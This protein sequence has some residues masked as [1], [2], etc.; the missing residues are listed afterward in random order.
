MCHFFIQKI[1]LFVIFSEESH[2]SNRFE[3]LYSCKQRKLSRLRTLCFLST[4]NRRLIFTNCNFLTCINAFY[5]IIADPQS[6]PLG[7]VKEKF[8]NSQPLLKINMKTF[9]KWFYQLGQFRCW[10]RTFSYSAKMTWYSTDTGGR[11]KLLHKE[12]GE[13]DINQASEKTLK[14]SDKDLR[15]EAPRHPV[16]RES[17]Q[18]LIWRNQKTRCRS[19]KL[20]FF[21]I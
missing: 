15:K 21:P 4:Q 12:R 20:L 1:F 5:R 8:S 9:W 6:D 18:A 16:T 7:T 13:Q 17:K 3:L 11:Q 19:K 10:S 2:F 14:S